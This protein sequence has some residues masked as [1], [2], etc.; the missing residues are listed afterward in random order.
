MTWEKVSRHFFVQNPKQFFVGAELCARWALLLK[1]EAAPNSVRKV[2]EYAQEAQD[3]FA[4]INAGR[5]LSDLAGRIYAWSWDSEAP[6]TLSEVV[7]SVAACGDIAINKFF[8]LPAAKFKVLGFTSDVFSGVRE[9]I[10]DYKSEA[11]EI[12]MVAVAKSI[13]SLFSTLVAIG[14]HFEINAY[15]MPRVTLVVDT[16]IFISNIYINI[17]KD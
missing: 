6:D 16:S 8:E 3:V 15:V 14:V 11:Y 17:N 10:S 12:K 13:M 7:G 9:L 5:A 4:W 2:A 1:G